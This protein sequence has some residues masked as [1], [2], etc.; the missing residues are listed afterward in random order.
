L[1]YNTLPD[2]EVQAKLEVHMNYNIAAKAQNLKTCY[3]EISE[4]FSPKII[5]EVNDVFIKVAKI[6]GDDIPWHNHKEE[7]ELFLIVKGEL[8]FESVKHGQ[9]IMKEGDIFVIQRGIDHKVS[10][11]NECWIMLIENKSTLH[12]GGIDSPIT[13]TIEEQLQ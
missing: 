12:T 11:E 10:A 1:A 9:F 8:L 3:S 5:G 7:D 13:K 2:S 4:Y 6:K